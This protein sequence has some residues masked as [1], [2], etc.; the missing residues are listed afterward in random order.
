MHSVAQA[1]LG[2]FLLSAV[3]AAM[4]ILGRAKGRGER[5]AEVGLLDMF[6][7]VA[8]G[9][10]LFAAG[11]A[12][13]RGLGELATELVMGISS[14]LAYGWYVY[15]AAEPRGTRHPRLARR[16]ELR[17]AFDRFRELLDPTEAPVKRAAR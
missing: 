6:G 5:G 11:W 1:L 10:S 13:S 15:R 14:V 9:L 8:L 3:T 17:R 2:L 12:R 7:V 4:V 16:A